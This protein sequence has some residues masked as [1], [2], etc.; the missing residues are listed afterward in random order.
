MEL[1]MPKHFFL[2]V[3]V[4]ILFSVVHT[5]EAIERSASPVINAPGI[6]AGTNAGNV[7]YGMSPVYLHRRFHRQGHPASSGPPL[8]LTEEMVCLPVPASVPTSPAYGPMAPDSAVR[9]DRKCH[10]KD[11]RDQKLDIP[12]CAPVVQACIPQDT[13]S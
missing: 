1:N 2:L 9:S 4:G 7:A 11:C 12:G 5:A 8:A 3:I 6:D 10:L 13:I